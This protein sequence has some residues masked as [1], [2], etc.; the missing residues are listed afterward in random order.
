[1]WPVLQQYVLSCEIM[2]RAHVIKYLTKVKSYAD[3]Q[4]NEGIYTTIG[5]DDQDSNL[6]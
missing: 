2:Q 4:V 3:M 5:P 1:M 6:N